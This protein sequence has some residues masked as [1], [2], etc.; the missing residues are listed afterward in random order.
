ML[1]VSI[2]TYHFFGKDMEVYLRN[3][4]EKEEVQERVSMINEHRIFIGNILGDEPK[5][6][7]DNWIDPKSIKSMISNRGESPLFVSEVKNHKKRFGI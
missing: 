5:L 7:Y 2:I 3:L 6:F 1:L 4:F